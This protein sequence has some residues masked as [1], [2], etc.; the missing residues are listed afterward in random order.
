MIM[1]YIICSLCADEKRKSVLSLFPALFVSHSVFGVKVRAI[2]NVC[3]CV[4]FVCDNV[5]A[6]RCITDR[7]WAQCTIYISCTFFSR[8]CCCSSFI[9]LLDFFF[10]FRYHVRFRCL[11]TSAHLL[12]ESSNS[13]ILFQPMYG[14]TE[15]MKMPIQLTNSP[16]FFFSFVRLQWKL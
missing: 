4:F 3:V 14:I 12:F 2:D 15:D 11:C 16:Y 10:S 9:R 7:E 6:E 13:A 1:F 8:S 5:Y